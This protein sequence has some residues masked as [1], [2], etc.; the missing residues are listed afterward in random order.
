MKT[1]IALLTFFAVSGLAV[2]TD[3][4]AMPLEKRACYCKPF[5]TVGAKKCCGSNDCSSTESCDCTG[6]KGCFCMQFTGFKACNSASD[7]NRVVRSLQFMNTLNNL[8]MLT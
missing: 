6:G 3:S 2:S 5:T 4:T 8:S 7:C 1:V